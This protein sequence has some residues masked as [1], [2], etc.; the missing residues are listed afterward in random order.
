MNNPVHYREYAPPDALRRHLRCAWHLRVDAAPGRV[1]T[2]YPDGC[3]EIIAHRAA[4]LRAYDAVRGWQPQVPLLFAGQQ[5][6]AVRL[7]A[8]SP[9]DCLGVRLQPAASATIA[10]GALPVLR[11]RIVD[12]ASLDPG[13]ALAFGNA[14]LRADPDAAVAAVFAVFGTHVA[15]IDPRVEAAVLELEGCDGDIPIA[16]L[17]SGNGMSRRAFQSLFRERVGLSAKEFA[18]IRRLQATI[19]L[20]DGGDTPVAEL[21][22]AGG[23]ADQAH[24]TRELRRVTGATPARLREALR[25]D[26]D[27]E[28]SVRLA[29]AF[30][31]GRLAT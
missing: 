1:D 13:F 11:D 14:A 26:R 17:A 16:D 6:T 15:Q 29:A 20:L 12:L 28:S 18:R 31:R 25:T 5:R 4:P 19:R 9:A 24:A 2:V 21:A 30:V 10:A 27:G 7:A 23:F 3:C 8:D 22:I